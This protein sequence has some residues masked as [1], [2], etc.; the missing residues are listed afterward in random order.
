MTPSQLY[1]YQWV[2]CDNAYSPIEGATSQS[3]TATAN[4]NYAVII[5]ID[6][7]SD[8]SV[9]TQITSVGVDMLLANDG[10]SV[11]PNPFSSQLT[12]ELKEN[13]KE[14][15]FEI[16]N[17]LGVIVFKGNI[18]NRT[19]IPTDKFTSGFYILKLE[20]GDSYE[21]LRLIKNR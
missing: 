20:N 21:L 1:E 14:R 15:Y 6:L 18:V 8:T 12:I 10:I 17:S 16:L 19:T 7:C 5:T 2:D 3:Y 11:Y 4:G 13:K 9:C